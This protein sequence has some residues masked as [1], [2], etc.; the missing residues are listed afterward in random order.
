MNKSV[1]TVAEYSL[2]LTFDFFFLLL[3]CK[4]LE[5]LEALFLFSDIS[6]LYI[7]IDIPILSTRNLSVLLL[8]QQHC[9]WKI[10]FLIWRI[11]LLMFLNI[12]LFLFL[13]GMCIQLVGIYA[14][15]NY[16]WLLIRIRIEKITSE[17]TLSSKI[18]HNS[19]WARLP[20]LE[21]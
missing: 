10:I 16:I 21:L 19:Y 15:G 14:R 7:L 6:Y 20:T 1:P 5:C 18:L 2:H 3:S 9:C 8:L 12:N 13:R 17:W 4:L 11:S